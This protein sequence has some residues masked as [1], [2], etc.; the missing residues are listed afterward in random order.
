M[1]ERLSERPRRRQKARA[2]RPSGEVLALQTSFLAPDDAVFMAELTRIRLLIGEVAARD[3]RRQRGGAHDQQVA[4]H[5]PRDVV[6]LLAPEM[7]GL[8]YDDF[9]VAT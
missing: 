4:I 2:V 7:E 5:H 9:R 6:N 8:P 3:G 1:G